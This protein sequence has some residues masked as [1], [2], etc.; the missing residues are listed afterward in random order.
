MTTAAKKGLFCFDLISLFILPYIM[1]P[2][3]HNMIMGSSRYSCDI[4]DQKAASISCFFPFEVQSSDDRDP[5]LCLLFFGGG[6]EVSPRKRGGTLPLFSLSI[7]LH[8]IIHEIFLLFSWKKHSFSTR[9]CFCCFRFFEVCYVCSLFP[10]RI[11]VRE[12]ERGGFFLCVF[13]MDGGS[14]NMGVGFKE[15]FFMQSACIS[16]KS[17]S[18]NPPALLQCVCGER[19]C[20][21]SFLRRKQLKM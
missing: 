16:P 14:G 3:V 1:I 5:S 18:Q 2:F 17:P 8:S 19:M 9:C 7:S 11:F 10:W 15:I 6:A 13:G 20:V 21:F 4:R 12:C